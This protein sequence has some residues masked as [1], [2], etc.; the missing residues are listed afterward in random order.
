GSGALRYMDQP[1]R[2]GRSIDNASQY[3]NG[4][5]VHHSSGVYNR[6]FYLLA[7]SPGWDTR[8]AFEVFVDANR[9]YWT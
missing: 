8:K 3:Y 5:D 1:S 9:Y 6:A 4:I 2:D 7:N